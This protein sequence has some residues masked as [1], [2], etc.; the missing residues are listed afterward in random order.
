MYVA[1]LMCTLMHAYCACQ[2]RGRTGHADGAC[3]PCIPTVNAYGACPFVVPALT[4]AVAYRG[5]C[6][7]PA[8]VLALARWEQ[9]LVPTLALALAACS[10]C[11]APTYALAPAG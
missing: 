5:L 4:P 2:F 8:L 10:S 11:L 1:R 7:V 3:L 6:L 9:F